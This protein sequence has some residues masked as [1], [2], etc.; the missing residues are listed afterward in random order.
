LKTFF[1]KLGAVSE[2][3]GDFCLRFIKRSLAGAIQAGKPL[4]A[5]KNA[6]E[7]IGL[8]QPSLLG[9]LFEYSAFSEARAS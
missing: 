3:R 6:G 5:G 1:S 9:T 8:I 7:F 4:N 2:R